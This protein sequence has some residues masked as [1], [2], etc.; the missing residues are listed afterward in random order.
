[1]NYTPELQE[2]ITQ[3]GLQKKTFLT[4]N[5][6]CLFARYPYRTKNVEYRDLTDFYLKKIF[7]KILN[8]ILRI[9]NQLLISYCRVGIVLQAPECL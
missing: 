7:E 9:L 8:V 1:M 4:H 5:T 2:K 6:E 3:L